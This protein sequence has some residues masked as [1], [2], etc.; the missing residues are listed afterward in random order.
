MPY[1]IGSY[2]VQDY[3]QWKRVFAEGAAW[4]QDRGVTSEQYFRNP[5]DRNNLVVLFEGEDVEELRYLWLSEEARQRR[6]RAG[7]LAETLYVPEG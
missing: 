5:Q 3:A 7:T 6:Q 2:R 1:I 4:R